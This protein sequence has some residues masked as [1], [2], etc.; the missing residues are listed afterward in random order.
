M[1][2]GRILAW[3]LPH[4]KLKRKSYQRAVH[5]LRTWGTPS[6]LLSWVPVIGDPLCFAAGWLRVSPAIAVVYIGTGKVLRY[7]AVLAVA[8]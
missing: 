6:L 7:L 2:R 4:E 8:R 3:R 1:R 5:R